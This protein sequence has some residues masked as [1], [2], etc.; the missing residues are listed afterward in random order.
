MLT[1]RGVGSNRE[2][3][4][5]LEQ[6]L[7]AEDKAA[8]LDQL[9]EWRK[10]RRRERGQAAIYAKLGEEEKA[11]VGISSSSRFAWRRATP[12]DADHISCLL[13]LLVRLCF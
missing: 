4:N 8:V 5:E 13:C 12:G 3:K 2:E 9:P 1:E 10:Q 7:S 11:K 6:K